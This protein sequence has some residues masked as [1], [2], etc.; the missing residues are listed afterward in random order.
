[1]DLVSASLE[2]KTYKEEGNQL[3]VA[4]EMVSQDLTI[5]V[6]F[7]V[8]CMLSFLENNFQTIFLIFE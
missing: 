6:V 1:M 2:G 8:L 5:A 3:I 4:A 7:S